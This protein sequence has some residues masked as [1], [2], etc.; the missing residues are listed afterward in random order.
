MLTKVH[1]IYNNEM[2]LMVYFYQYNGLYALV[3]NL[4]TSLSGIVNKT[5]ILYMQRKEKN[6]SMSDY[7]E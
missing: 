3:W 7:Y 6:V 5:H 2:S 1:S 4:R